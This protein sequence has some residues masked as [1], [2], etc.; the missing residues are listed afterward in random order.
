MSTSRNLIIN[1]LP[2]SVNEAKLRSLFGDSLL[3]E[4]KVV[5]DRHTKVSLGYGFIKFFEEKNAINAVKEKNGLEIDG[6]SL[7]V[8]YARPASPKTMKCKLYVTNLPKSYGQKEVL[9]LFGQFGD[10]IECRVLKD[11]QNHDK[12][13]GVAFVLFAHR[14]QSDAALSL[15]NTLIEGAERSVRVKYSDDNHRG[16]HRTRDSHCDKDVAVTSYEPERLGEVKALKAT[17]MPLPV[18]LDSAG[19]TISTAASLEE[20]ATAQSPGGRNEYTAVMQRTMALHNQQLQ[21][22]QELQR[23]DID[24][25]NR[26]E[27]IRAFF[28]GE[29]G[30]KIRGYTIYPSGQYYVAPLP[31]ASDGYVH[32]TEQQ[33]EG[34]PAEVQN[35]YPHVAVLGTGPM[36]VPA[37]YAHVQ[38]QMAQQQ[39]YTQMH[40]HLQYT[41][42]QHPQQVLLTREVEPPEEQRDAE[43]RGPGAV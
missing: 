31:K 6:K 32:P 21:Q 19:S 29:P 24:H 9:E 25:I 30:Q 34:P 40:Q 22:L 13:K 23:E 15:D 10:I 2:Y 1:Y 27:H 12:Y 18:S 39:Y 11:S 20:C 41:Q 33:S 17:S 16:Q 36:L 3:E 14:E 5:R 8:S 35:P 26:K 4:V 43:S 7:K 38:Q 42:A 37:P 28:E